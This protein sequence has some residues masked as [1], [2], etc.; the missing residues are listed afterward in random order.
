MDLKINKDKCIRCFG[1]ISV[2]PVQALQA[3][4]DGPKWDKSKC[5]G[6]NGCVDFCPVGALKLIK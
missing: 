1:C 6:C 4:G 3:A 2:C 5:I